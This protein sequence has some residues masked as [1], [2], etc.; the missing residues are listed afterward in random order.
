MLEPSGGVGLMGF[1]A[2]VCTR[3]ES[4]FK[5]SGGVGLGPKVLG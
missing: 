5:S 2:K 3:M 1:W 4:G